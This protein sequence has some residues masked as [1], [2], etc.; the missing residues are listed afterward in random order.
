MY[1]G[2][3]VLCGVGL[4]PFARGKAASWRVA[5]KH[6]SQV[7]KKMEFTKSSKRLCK[8]TELA[9][10][11]AREDATMA[12]A[13]PKVCK[14]KDVGGI[15]GMLAFMDA[16]KPSNPVCVVE[17]QVLTPIPQCVL[18]CP[19]CCPTVMELQREVRILVEALE[20]E[21]QQTA[22]AIAG[23]LQLEKRLAGLLPSGPVSYRR[24]GQ[25]VM[26]L[27]QLLSFRRRRRSSPT[28]RLV[29]GR[30]FKR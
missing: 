2:A 11:A 29:N 26:S 27:A 17:S 24:D 25:H 9:D 5:A 21:R 4:L 20:R 23:L 6:A 28:E 18:D 3:M 10:I 1:I 16:S 22:T 30:F 15:T 19:C 7:R 12:V 8:K 13:P 14:G